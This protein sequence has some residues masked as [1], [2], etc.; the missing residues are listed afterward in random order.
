MYKV[1]INDRSIELTDKFEDYSSSYDTLFI[2]FASEQALFESI[3]LLT[4][5][6]VVKKLVVYHN[7]LEK[8]WEIFT[9]HYKCIVAAGGLVIKDSKVLMIYKNG[10]WDLPKGKIDGSESPEEAAKRE[11]SEECGLT[12]LSVGETLPISY[13]LFKENDNWLLKKT[14]WFTMNSDTDGPLVG[15]KNEG[16]TEVKW[17]DQSSWEEA[18]NKSYSSVIQMLSSVF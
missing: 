11:V 16:I 3:D 13:Y 7:E 2:H 12:S 8:L 14:H 10:F 15:D 4:A 9:N 6:D 17:M 18:K 5:S 1:F